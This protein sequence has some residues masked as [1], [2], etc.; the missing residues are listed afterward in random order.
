MTV[1]ELIKNLQ[2]YNPD[3]KITVPDNENE[4]GDEF[5]GTQYP[6]IITECKD[7]DI[8]IA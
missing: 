2:R 7:G 4:S 3:A 1:R 8:L 6:S 5:T